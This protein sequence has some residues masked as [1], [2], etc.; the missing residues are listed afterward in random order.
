MSRADISRAFATA[1]DQVLEA[2]VVGSFTRA[3]SA[4]RSRLT[5]WEHPAQDAMRG[6]TALVTGATSGLGAALATQLAGLGCRVLVVGRNASK[7]ADTVTRLEDD[8]ADVVGEQADLAHLSQVRELADRIDEPIDVLAHVAGVMTESREESAD[9]IELTAQVHVVAP[10]LL[11]SRLLDRLRARPD[12][13]VITMSSGGMYTEKLDVDE[14][15]DPPEPFDGT[16]QYARAK[17]AQVVL[18]EEW[19]R[20]HPA[21]GIGFHAMHPG[22][23]DTPG[24]ETSLPT[25]R[26]VV[27]PALRTPDE[28]ADTAA[29]LA[30]SSSVTPPGGDFW[31]DRRRRRTISLP[32]TKADRSEHER[33]W[34]EVA[35]RAGVGR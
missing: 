9:G 6:R 30:W 14:L 4:V 34:T 2:T 23:A 5:G 26:R 17:R 22:W 20:R 3:G 35:R 15:F 13:R 18:N 11:T 25:F 19:A 8:G 1:V 27:G 10:F 32:G 21:D 31:H 16:T 7:L 33:L 12:A 28:G 24:I 29:W